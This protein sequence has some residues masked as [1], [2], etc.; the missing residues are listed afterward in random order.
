MKISRPDGFTLIELLVVIAII[1]VLATLIAGGLTASMAQAKAS[2]CK[3][4]LR[5]IGMANQLYAADHH[6]HF[7]AAAADLMGTNLQRWHGERD[8]R[9]DVFSADRGPLISYLEDH[10]A[11][12]RCPSLPTV[13]TAVADN[14]FESSCGGYGYNS[15]GIGSMSYI[16]GFHA[17]STQKGLR[18]SLL[19]H[20]L[21]TLMLAD[22]A[23][24]Q[25]YRNPEYL[26]EY[27][28]TEP[29]FFLSWDSTEESGRRATPSIHFRHRRD[30]AQI[31]WADGH[32]DAHPM[33]FSDGNAFATGWPGEENNDLF[34]P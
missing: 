21:D 9:R 17:E 15:I 30:T 31:Y 33:G 8:S 7:V 4:N 11:L 27:S 22:T 14:A 1:G 2:T 32:V 16:N 25:P 13:H 19:K 24:P 26:I 10:A 12:R 29:V 5:Q 3:S 23:F 34:R 20:P 18:T 28:F 6:D